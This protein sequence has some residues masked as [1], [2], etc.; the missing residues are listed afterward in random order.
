ML[1]TMQDRAL[2]IAVK[3]NSVHSRLRLCNKLT[4]VMLSLKLCEEAVEFA[5]VAVDV[6]LT[7][8]KLKQHVVPPE[9]FIAPITCNSLGALRLFLHLQ[10]LVQFKVV[11]L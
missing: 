5:H 11:Q 8:G 7:L 1:I 4:E 3:S 10:A 9:T 2:P 6:S